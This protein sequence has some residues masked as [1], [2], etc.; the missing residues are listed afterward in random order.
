MFYVYILTSKP[1]G[2]LYVGV[3]CTLLRRVWEHKSKAVPGF[4]RRYVVDHLVWFETRDSHNAALRREKK[5]K[6]W[7]CD[8]KVNL[9]APENRRWLDLSLSLTL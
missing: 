9:V 7:K 5:I 6:E 2:T 1:Y 3:T 4:T 8:W